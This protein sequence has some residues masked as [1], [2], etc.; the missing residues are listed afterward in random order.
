MLHMTTEFVSGQKYHLH[1]CLYSS[2]SYP[3]H[4]SQVI[5]RT[6][7]VCFDFLYNL[8]L[9][10]F[11][12]CKEFIEIFSWSYIG[13]HV[14]Y[15]LWQSGFNEIWILSTDFLKIHKYKISRKSVQW[16]PSFPMWTDGQTDKLSVFRVLQTCLKI[17]LKVIQCNADVVVSGCC[18]IEQ[19]FWDTTQLSD[20]SF[21]LDNLTTLYFLY[22]ALFMNIRWSIYGWKQSK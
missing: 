15:P 3:A 14:K 5:Y 1:W 12:F 9:K 7:N 13:L 17:I 11:S 6:W 20:V 18:C 4:K 16:E 10:K 8:C 22:F 2:L 21:L 19:E